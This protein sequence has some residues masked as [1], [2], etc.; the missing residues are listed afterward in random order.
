MRWIIVFA[1]AAILT[2]T[3]HAA[4]SPGVSVQAP[5]VSVQVA[6]VAPVIATPAP[7]IAAPAPVYLPATVYVPRVQWVPATPVIERRVYPTPLRDFLFGRWGVRY[8]PVQP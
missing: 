6:P 4:E 1:L 2:A 8:V 3:A 5:G 7:V